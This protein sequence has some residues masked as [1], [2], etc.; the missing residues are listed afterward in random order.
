MCVYIHIYIYIYIYKNIFSQC[1]QST[2]FKPQ[3]RTDEH[4]LIMWLLGHLIS[5]KVG[6]AL[7]SPLLLGE[8]WRAPSL[9]GSYVFAQQVV[10]MRETLS[11]VCVFVWMWVC[12]GRTCREA[13]I[14]LAC[15]PPCLL[16][17]QALPRGGWMWTSLF[18]WAA[19]SHFKTMEARFSHLF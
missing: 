4:N 11:C 13:P 5:L 17:P 1:A 10:Q 6:W 16:G 8:L 15:V 9:H 12:T 14:L 2:V 19:S 3:T 7:L 18:W